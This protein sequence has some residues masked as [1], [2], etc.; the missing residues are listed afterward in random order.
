MIQE[1]IVKVT[2]HQIKHT[3]FIDFRESEKNTDQVMGSIFF[4]GCVCLFMNSEDVGFF[5]AGW[6]SRAMDRSAQIV[7]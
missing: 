7:L 1:K 4:I 6:E 2:L 3:S 5:Q